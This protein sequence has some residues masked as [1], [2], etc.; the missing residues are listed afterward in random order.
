MKLSELTNPENK[1]L[2]KLLVEAPGTYHQS[3]T[4]ANIS[5]IAARSIRANS[6]LGTNYRSGKHS[7]ALFIE[8][9]IYAA[10][11]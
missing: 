5:E 10:M 8:R 9:S 4:V 2:K 6:L 3:L 1:L 7:P 11:L